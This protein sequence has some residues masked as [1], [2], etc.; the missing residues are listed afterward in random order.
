MPDYTYAI[1]KL[2]LEMFLADA[3]TFIRC[4]N[5]FDPELFDQRLRA[6]AKFITQHVDQYKVMPDL[7]QVNAACGTELDSVQTQKENYEWLLDQ[8]EQFTRHKA[9][10]RAI[11]RSADLL[12][13]GDY[14]PVERLI[15]EAI[16]ISLNKDMGTD[17][18]ENPRSRLEGLKS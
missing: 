12:E 9:L 6:P 4:Q 7:I 16:Q 11:I 14:N 2:Y 8:F 18:F 13:R 10:E 15:K 1:Q 17:Y 3:E 5:I